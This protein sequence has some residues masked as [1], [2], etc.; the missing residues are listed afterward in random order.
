MPRE[1]QVQ[2]TQYFQWLVQLYEAAGRPGK[3]EQWR[4][5]LKKRETMSKN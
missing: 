5:K 2:V 1:A 3:A 4:K